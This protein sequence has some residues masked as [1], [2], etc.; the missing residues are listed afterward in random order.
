LLD[1]VLGRIQITENEPIQSFLVYINQRL[2]K[3]LESLLEI[4]ENIRAG[5]I[6][7]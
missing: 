3:I 4:H 5:T 6:N 7:E 1:K 2:M